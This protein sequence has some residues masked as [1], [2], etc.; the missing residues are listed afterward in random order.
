ME[1]CSRSLAITA[2]LDCSSGDWVVVMDCDLQDRPESIPQL[3]EK[4]QEGYDAVFAQ[5]VNR[6][7]SK[8]TKFFSR[9]FYKVYEYF[10]E[11]TYD[12]SLSNFSIASRKVVD[13]Y[14]SMREHHRAYTMFI[15][16]IGFKQTAIPLEGDERF[17]GTSSYNF[18]KKM[19]LAAQLITAQSNKPLR[20]AMNVGFVIALVALIV[21]I[22]LGINYLVNPENVMMGWTSS[23]SATFLMGGLNLAAIGIAGI[24]IGNIFTEAKDRPIY[25]VA[26]RLNDAKD[27]SSRE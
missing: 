18:K 9:M 27:Q 10:T 15:K 22:I 8:S 4:A 24:Y 2:G 21:L 16:W 7:D 17:E 12:P 25:I 13:S 1:S 19:T 20:F 14:C 26:E 23:V 5:R 3:Y 6:K 11:G